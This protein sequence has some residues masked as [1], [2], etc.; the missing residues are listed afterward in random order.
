[1]ANTDR[2]EDIVAQKA[3]TDI[4]TLKEVMQDLEA[5]FEKT[6]N[7]ATRLSNAVSNVKGIK[8]LSDATKKL[9][10]EN[11]ELEKINKQIDETYKKRLAAETALAKTLAEEKLLLQQVNAETKEQIKLDNAAEGSIEKKRLQLTQL[12]KQY[13]KLGEAQRNSADGKAQLENLKALDAELK[14][15]EGST[16]RFQRNVGNYNGSAKIIVEALEKEKVKLQNLTTQ[17]QSF[18]QQV[19]TQRNVVLGF[20]AANNS[21]EFQQAQSQLQQYEAQMASAGQ[22]I[23]QTRVVVEGFARVTEKPSFLKLSGEAVDAQKELKALTKSLIEM[24]QQGLGNTDAANKLRKQLAEMTDQIADT[25]AEI[26]ALSSDTRSFD[27]FA[28]SITFAADAFQTAAGAAVLF[29]A[30]EEEA[31]ETTKTLTAVTSF[32]NGVKGIANELTTRGTAANKVYAFAQLQVKTAMDATATSAARLR[33]VLITVGI[34]AIVIGIGLLIANFDKLKSAITGTTKA[35]EDLNEARIEAAK[36]AAV[37]ISSLDRLYK[38]ATNTADGIDKQRASA[39]EL[40]KTYPVTFGNFT[41]EEIMLGRAKAGYEDLSKAILANALVKAKQAIIEKNAMKFAEEDQKRQIEIDKLREQAKTAST[42]RQTTTKL[43][44]LGGG[45]IEIVNDKANLETKISILELHKKAKKDIFDADNKN[46]AD[47]VA[48]DKKTADLARKNEEQR[49]KNENDA[50]QKKSKVN[51]AGKTGTKSTNNDAERQA[52]DLKKFNEKL[53]QDELTARRE[54]EKQKE[55]LAIE[56]FKR[57]TDNE[58]LSINERLIG[59]AFYQDA[60]TEQIKKQ[61]AFEEQAIIDSASKELLSITKQ[62]ELTEKQKND[63]LTKTAQQRLAIENKAEQDITTLQTEAVNNRNKIFEDAT[64][65]RLAILQANSEKELNIISKDEADKLLEIEKNFNS[66][67][68]SKEQ[69]EAQK[70]AIENEF[71]AKRIQSEIDTAEKLLA[72]AKANGQDTSKQETD[73]AKLKLDLARAN[74]KAI[75]DERQ[76]D[77]ELEKEANS[78][79]K[80]LYK[81]LYSGVKDLVFQFI[82]DGFER[83]KNNLEKEKIVLDERKDAELKR[84]NAL[85]ISEEEKANKIKIL[86]ANTQAQKEAIARRQKQLDIQKAKVDKVKAIFDIGVNIATRQVEALK[87]LTNPVTAPLYPG[88]AALIGA[89]GA[90]QLAAVIA[91]PIPQYWKGTQDAEGG[92]SWVGERGK[93]LVIEPTGITYETP[94]TATLV[95]LPKH[96]KVINHGQYMAALKNK[97][98]NTAL[99]G[100][101]INEQSIFK[102]QLQNAE[103]QANMIVSAIKNTPKTIVNVSRGGIDV[104]EKHGQS[105]TNYIDKQIRYRN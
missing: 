17:Y 15:L 39:I 44:E 21:I 71:A 85:N 10:D 34:G 68:I 38:A 37:E 8:G 9:N 61:A 86:D 32:A 46:F 95:N 96:S 78:K 65:K 33:A 66:G 62:K 102:M 72:I 74:T 42:S 60:K 52:E 54:I 40:Q 2:I 59:N 4:K 105:Y 23:E 82:D 25:K 81:E 57:I 87:Y 3:F 55:D 100:A 94:S 43:T 99:T 48:E 35:Q 103:I 18:G 7:N 45:D 41:V 75:D 104:L 92:I 83:Q 24:E 31:A 53:S 30:S 28:G 70:L 93:E 27:L 91:R 13:D 20:G 76:K 63:I 22:Q 36:S 12:Q 50:L 98:N 6:A 16:G 64:A 26:K 47:A 49:I 89:I 97:T 84:I 101:I 77:L 11:G 58:K 88:I 51:V 19:Q 73:L 69:Y 67:L 1:M 90:V 14:E 80:E 29:G 79:K 56:T 5:Q